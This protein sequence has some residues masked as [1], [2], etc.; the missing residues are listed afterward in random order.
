[1]GDSVIRDH[2]NRQLIGLQI[3]I[4]GLSFS[5]SSTTAFAQRALNS[6]DRRQATSGS[7]SPTISNSQL[8]NGNPTEVGG[9]VRIGPGDELDI[10]VFGLPEL[11]QHVRVGS[12]GDISLPLVGTLHFAG[13]TSEEAQTLLEKLLA[14]GHFVNNPHVSVYVK[15]YTTEGISLI[16]EVSRPGVYPALG[17]HRLLDLIQ[18]AGGLTEK[19]GRTVTVSHRDDPN[20]PVT[21]AFSD[22]VAKMSQN[23]IELLPGDTVVISKA[24]IVYVVGEVNRPGGFVIEGN[25]I[26]A[27]QALAM[28][29]GPSHSASLNR[30]RM[31]RRTPDG[32]KDIPLPLT[33]ILQAKTPDVALEPNDIVFV[34]ES[35]LKGV[36]GASNI[37]SLLAS[38]AIYRF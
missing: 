36:V 24:G 19:A 31:I 10:T 11:S 21:L 25:M 38:A 20:N 12:S 13:L 33:K 28:A 6:N 14:D 27:S 37:V 16:G 8:R 17:A 15:E 9:A 23:N 1:M 7:P 32:L 26:M 29:A 4:V 35:R 3:L 34:P 30:A 5:L 18:S 22:D 2:L